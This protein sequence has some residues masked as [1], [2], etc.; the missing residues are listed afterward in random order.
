MTMLN[1]SRKNKSARG[2]S[3]LELVLALAVSSIVVAFGVTLARNSLQR[4]G[5][6]AEAREKNDR[7][8]SFGDRLRPDIEAAGL[9]MVRLSNESAGT[10]QVT[11]SAQT[12][13]Q[14]TG[15]VISTLAA[16]GY[17]VPVALGSRTIREGPGGIT[18]TVTNPCQTQFLVTLRGSDGWRGIANECGETY[19][20]ETI[21]TTGVWNTGAFTETD[22]SPATYEISIES[23]PDATYTVRYYRTNSGGQRRLLYTSP[24]ALPAF[25]LS[26][27]IQIYTQGQIDGMTLTG[28]VIGDRAVKP[29][30]LPP[31]PNSDEGRPQR[32]VFLHTNASGVADGFTLLRGDVT[33]DPMRLDSVF[34]ARMFIT[35]PNPLWIAFTAPPRAQ[36]AAGDYVLLVD[37]P[38]SRSL[39]LSVNDALAWNGSQYLYLRPALYSTAAW[40]RFYSDQADINYVFQPGAIV[41]K[42]DAPVEYRW[43][44]SDTLLRRVG[45]Q[46]WAVAATGVT[47]FNVSEVTTTN[48][49]GLAVSA[50]LMSDTAFGSAD[51]NQ[52]KPV[53]FEETFNPLP[54]NLTLTR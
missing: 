11:I 27:G 40:G 34:D 12:N 52:L 16:R 22:A 7:A 37:Y 20:Q 45:D 32:P 39:L 21:S 31:L 44:G 25:P 4:V 53:F 5:A 42:L 8:A 2:F 18:F 14:Q 23:K 46:A 54:L 6:N 50:R 38:A 43:D 15:T 35:N 30:V 24:Y 49:Y 9:N 48:S 28:S 33:T 47:S 41:L 3:L 17:T 10:E 29:F 36:Y 1:K 51:R 26:V 19:T 13:Y